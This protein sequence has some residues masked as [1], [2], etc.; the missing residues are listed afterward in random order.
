MPSSSQPAVT[1]AITHHGALSITRAAIPPAV[2]AVAAGFTAKPDPRK[3]SCGAF[4]VLLTKYRHGAC[5]ISGTGWSRYESL[6][7]DLR[8]LHKRLR[9]LCLNE[10]T[11][12][13]CGE[14]YLAS[15][16]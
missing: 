7:P 4:T 12:V 8:E 11:S 16:Y 9:G 3:L 2:P 1:T 6:L 10:R 14:P 13:Y 5:P 15:F